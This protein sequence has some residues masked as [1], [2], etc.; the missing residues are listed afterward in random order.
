MNP[1]SR[2]AKRA[3]IQT[4]NDAT[5]DPQTGVQSLSLTGL[6]SLSLILYRGCHRSPFHILAPRPR[7]FAQGRQSLGAK[8]SHQELWCLHRR[9]QV[10]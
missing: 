1:V 6:T 4:L 3:L 10:C 5:L 8:L 2:E 9:D 7:S